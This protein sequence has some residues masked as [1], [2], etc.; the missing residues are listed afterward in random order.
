M[1]C[2]WSVNENCWV[3][4]GWSRVGLSCLTVAKA[5]ISQKFPHPPATRLGEKPAVEAW[6]APATYIPTSNLPVTSC[7][8]A[9]QAPDSSLTWAAGGQAPQTPRLQIPVQPLSLYHLCEWALVSLVCQVGNLG[10]LSPLSSVSRGSLNTIESI[11]TCH[12]I[13]SFWPFPWSMP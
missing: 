12:K 10:L 8:C 2:R 5:K 1:L 7:Y 6:M 3:I 9:S 11:W 4:R 13:C